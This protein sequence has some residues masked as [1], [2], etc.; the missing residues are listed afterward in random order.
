LQVWA[1][2]FSSCAAGAGSAGRRLLPVAVPVGALAGFRSGDA[3]ASDYVSSGEQSFQAGQYDQ[4][5]KDWQHALVDNPNN[6][7]VILLMAQALFA[8]GKYDNAAGAVQAGMQM[9][10]QNEWG[11]V[12]K[13]YTQVYS[14]I[15]KYTDQLKALENARNAKP[16]DPAMRFVLGYHFG[17]LGYP[18]QA[19]AELDKAL[20][21]Q[22]KDL[23]SQELRDIF[24]VQAGL[25]ARPHT[26]TEQA[27]PAGQAPAAA[28]APQ[29]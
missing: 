1:S 19:V 4:A 14:N 12:V 28:P 5:L 8:L 20:A 6:G 27:P 21:L 25:P 15:Q 22:P 17:Y 3:A 16:D 29:S 13:N 23:G 18:K 26:A 11:N 24:A 9:L 7:G 2:V 10:P